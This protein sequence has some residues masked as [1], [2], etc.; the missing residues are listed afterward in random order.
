MNVR[1][2][3]DPYKAESNRRKHKISFPQAARVFAD[4]LRLSEVARIV[5]GEVRW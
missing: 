5:E 1:F 2:T 4:P 3:W